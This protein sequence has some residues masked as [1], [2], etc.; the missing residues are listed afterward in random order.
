M[1]ACLR[2]LEMA[3]A[4][5]GEEI[6]DVG[7][8]PGIV[9]A[10][11]PQAE[12]AV[13][14]L[15]R[16][17][18]LDGVLDALV[19]VAVERELGLRGELVDIEHRHRAAGDLLGT[20]E[21]IAVELVEQRGD[22]ERSRD[23]DRQADAAGARH[24][25]GEHVLRQRQRLA[26]RKRPH[27]PARQDLVCRPHVERDRCV[28]SAK[29]S[30]P[31]TL[32]FSVLDPAPAADTG[33]ATWSRCLAAS[34][35][36]NGLSPSSLTVPSLLDRDVVVASRAFDVVEFELD[37]AAVAGAQE[38]RQRRG[39]H[40][41]IAHNDVARGLADLVLAP[42]DRHHAYGAGEGGNIE[43]HLR[44]AVGA[45]ADNA[46]IERERRLRR[47]RAGQFGAAVAARADRP[48]H[49]LHAVDQLPVEIADFGGELAL[50]EIVFVWRR[51]L[52][53]G[54]IED[55]D[56]DGGDDD[57]RL[58]A[59]RKPC[60][61]DRHV[62]R[63]VGPHGGRQLHVERERALRAVD[64]EPLHADGAPRHALRRRIERTAQGRNQIGAGAPVLAD[65][66]AAR[67]RPLL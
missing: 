63:I 67:A 4:R 57:V 58:L 17:Q 14:I 51:R 2:H 22:V 41:G 46:G 28:S 27:G 25:V 64:R 44:G 24:E 49:A 40:H 66:Q 54:E 5:P 36:V 39:Q 13:R 52:V 15:P 37:I 62:E 30:G 21:R 47:R 43:A 65:R 3:L 6:G 60:E 32:T 35:S 56:I 10:D 26:G 59:G 9:A 19:D 61:L 16:Q 8:E 53:I 23:R 29:P 11:R 48:A 50:T 31:L 38:T 42:G 18:T 1:N 45:D 33:T 20:A 34:L 7:V 12:R 55:A